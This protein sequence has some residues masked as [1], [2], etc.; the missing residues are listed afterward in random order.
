[1][2]YA[3]HYLMVRFTPY[4]ETGEFA[5]IGLVVYCQKANYF[6]SKFSQGHSRINQFFSGLDHAVAKAGI[7]W[8]QRE[9][10][11]L[12]KYRNDKAFLNVLKNLS[13]NAGGLISFTEPGV[14]LVES[15]AAFLD[16]KFADMVEH[17]FTKEP[18]YE[19][20]MTR[21]VRALLQSRLE[22]YSF[23]AGKLGSD[24]FKVELPLVQK[25]KFGQVEKAI[26]PLHLGKDDPQQLLKHALSWAT[27]LS[28]VIQHDKSIMQPSDIL[29]VADKPA[30]SQV[31]GNTKIGMAYRE[32]I[33]SFEKLGVSVA[34]VDDTND[35]VS[36]A[37][38]H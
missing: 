19:Q 13:M 32:A 37:L 38:R 23:K 27:N 28:W 18:A 16:Q 36:F 9:L 15:P 2:K 6:A 17:A 29:V 11:A 5:N 4:P 26:K 20:Q 8:A 25:S 24:L 21:R 10:D 3:C 22:H 14:A 7:K 30:E 31:H 34:N 12:A 35:I 33:K 1:M